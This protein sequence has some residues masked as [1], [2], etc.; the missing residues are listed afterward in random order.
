[1]KWAM[2]EG[3]TPQQENCSEKFGHSRTPTHAR[4]MPSVEVQCDAPQQHAERLSQRVDAARHAYFRASQ[5]YK[6]VLLFYSASDSL[7]PVRELAMKQAR[8]AHTE[9]YNLYVTVLD[10]LA[11]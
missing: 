7:D 3:A 2:K 4:A 10:R 11:T 6:R 9:A 1:M 8:Q 5:E